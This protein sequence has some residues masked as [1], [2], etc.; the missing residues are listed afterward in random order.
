MSS[1]VADGLRHASP[2][3][4][5]DGEGAARGRAV[6]RWLQAAHSRQTPCVSADLPAPGTGL[7]LAEGVLTEAEYETAYPFL[8]Q[9]AG[10]CPLADETSSVVLV[11]ENIYGYDHDA[12]VV[13]VIRPDLLYRAGDRLVIREFKTAER[14]YESGRN[15][16][17]DRHLQVP[18]AIAMLNSGLLARYGAS[19]GRLS[20]NYLPLRSL[21]V[22]LGCR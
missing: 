12:E 1:S 13:P 5:G 20:W 8:L 18:F 17:Y 3:E 15:E 11:D 9:H 6:H 14:P 7:G 22:D 19:N 21:R 10:C 2:W 4:E 16:A